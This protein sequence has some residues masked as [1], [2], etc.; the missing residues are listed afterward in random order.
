M[1]GEYYNTHYV[2]C[3]KESQLVSDIFLVTLPAGN[4][5]ITAIYAYNTRI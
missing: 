3:M 4:D 1:V 2:E 5:T